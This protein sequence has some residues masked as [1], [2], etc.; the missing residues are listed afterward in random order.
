MS[1]I[2]ISNPFKYKEVYI[3]GD[4]TDNIKIRI[5]NDTEFILKDGTYTFWY[6][7][8]DFH[9]IC[10]TLPFKT[11][12]N[13]ILRNYIVISNGYYDYNYLISAII[14]GDPY[15]L[16]LMGNYYK[17]NTTYQDNEYGDHNR[18]IMI[19]YY[20]YAANWNIIQAMYI[21]GM[22]YILESP[23]FN[24]F[25]AQKYLFMAADNGCLHAINSLNFY[26]NIKHINRFPTVCTCSYCRVSI[27]I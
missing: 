2:T 14:A 10:H 27:K 20:T 9:T 26:Y 25:N 23:K 5:Y 16:Y 8:E 11:D 1:A 3:I 17:Y 18:N 4:L 6:V 13:G 24:K 12:R 15:S 22:H 21:L 7:I 19:T